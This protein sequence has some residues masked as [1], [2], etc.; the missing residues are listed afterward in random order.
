MP[1]KICSDS[2]QNP[3]D[4]SGEGG[5]GQTPKK[6]S[7]VEVWIFLEPHYKEVQEKINTIIFQERF[8]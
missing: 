6:P 3:L 1:L 7:F 8:M 2:S 5:G 4:S